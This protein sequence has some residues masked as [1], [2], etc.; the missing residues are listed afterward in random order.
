MSQTYD[1]WKNIDELKDIMSNTRYSHLSRSQLHVLWEAFSDMY[2]ASW[3]IYSTDLI[4]SFVGWLGG[5]EVFG[6][7]KNGS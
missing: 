2:C 7:N 4:D 5:K 6:G 3:L 1:S